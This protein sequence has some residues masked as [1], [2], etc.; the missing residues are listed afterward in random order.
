[1]PSKHTLTLVDNALD[2]LSYRVQE[3]PHVARKILK[4]CEEV[5][6][7]PFSGTGKPEPL[8]YLKDHT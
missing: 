3:D 1:M 4:F 8:K 7:T 6:R 5:L 2:G